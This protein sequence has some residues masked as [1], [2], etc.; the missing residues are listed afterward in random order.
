V[1]NKSET[2]EE[3]GTHQFSISIKELGL[4]KGI[5]FIEMLVNEKK[6]LKKFAIVE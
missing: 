3:K 1:L 2:E 5:Y 6:Q 4:T